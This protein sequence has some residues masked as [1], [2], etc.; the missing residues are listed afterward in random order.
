MNN[1]GFMVPF[2]R[3]N[4]RLA[5][6][7]WTITSEKSTHFQNSSAR[8][9]QN[10]AKK[11]LRKLHWKFHDHAEKNSNFK[12]RVSSQ[13]LFPNSINLASFPGC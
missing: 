4:E 10:V 11:Q 2:I 5:Y 8:S 12:A 7:M 1:N 3:E 9:S 13:M 6:T